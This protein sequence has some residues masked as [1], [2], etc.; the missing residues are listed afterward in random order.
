MA[1]DVESVNGQGSSRHHSRHHHHR[2]QLHSQGHHHH[3]QPEHYE[4]YRPGT[5]GVLNLVIRRHIPG[6]TDP[7]SHEIPRHP[8]KYLRPLPSPTPSPPPPP[9]PPPPQM[10]MQLIPMLQSPLPPP[11]A[12]YPTHDI[13]VTYNPSPRVVSRPSQSPKSG[14]PDERPIIPM[15]DT[16]V[17]RRSSPG[18]P[19]LKKPSR[20][21]KPMSQ[22]RPVQPP[23]VSPPQY[24]PEPTP[25]PK[26]RV[27]VNTV[28][29]RRPIRLDIIPK[30]P[31]AQPSQRARARPVLVEEYE[32]YYPQPS[33]RA[34]PK[35]G[36][37]YVVVPK[38]SSREIEEYEE[39][40]PRRAA[41]VQGAPRRKI[42]YRS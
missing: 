12:V 21:K 26:S 13:R 42:I 4:P 8:P 37:P 27:R 30:R 17:Y 29:E 22:P 15:Q 23:P 39:V 24:V 5:D 9:P 35:E 33:V 18:P 14:D 31:V 11:S 40:T 28:P 20:Q 7:L 41:R 6:S 25:V 19:I 1:S 38:V 3:E 32:E 16:S 34:R 36:I 2:H 10:Q